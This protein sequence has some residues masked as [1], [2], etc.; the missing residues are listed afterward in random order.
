MTSAAVTRPPA[1]RALPLG[2]PELP[3]LLD[4]LHRSVA[5]TAAVD[6]PHE[7]VPTAAVVHGQVLQPWAGD[8]VRL[9]V[10]EADGSPVG[11][12]TVELPVHDNL[13]LAMT[14]LHVASAHRRAGT[15]RLLWHAVLDVA[16]EAGRR[17]LLMEA[18]DGSAAEAFA[19][20]V[21]A[22]PQLTEVRRQQVLADVDPA[23]VARL[24]AD[25]ERAARGYRLEAWSGPAP[26]H[27][28]PLVAEA[29]M[30]LNDAPLG[31][32]DYEDERWDA[33]RVSVRDAAVLAW[34]LR[35]QSLLALAADGTPAGYTEV[36]VSEDGTFAWQWGT[37]VAP[38]HRGHR[39]GM[40]LKATMVERLRA[41]EP[42][43]AVVSTT[44]AEDN[45]HMVAVNDALGYRAVDRVTEWQVEV[46]TE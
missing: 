35:V 45:A 27:L 28:R 43:V 26:E 32:L 19:R 10:A 20:A 29:T 34:G 25:A 6:R 46:P 38:A 31:T 23:H 21:G 16:R 15:G 12:A 14:E 5:E 42:A 24:R 40:L 36:A 3:A 41:L 18:R 39:L 17:T 2:S 37:A 11:W 33:E 4:A 7:P 22:E 1:L 9:V 13:H 44:N 8:P 30:S